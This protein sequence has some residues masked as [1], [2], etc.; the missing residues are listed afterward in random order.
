LDWK[1]IKEIAFGPLNLSHDVFWKL[2]PSEF[3][4]LYE[5]WQWRENR[6]INELKDLH[7]LE[8]TRLAIL[9]SWITAPHLKKPKKP[10]DFYDPNKSKEK[11]KTT[12]AESKRVV[13]ELS[14]ELGVSEWPKR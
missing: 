7:E 12:P 2:T 11:K 14:K 10:T 4:E 8:L 3:L 13:D 5:G 1:W 9:A 6:R